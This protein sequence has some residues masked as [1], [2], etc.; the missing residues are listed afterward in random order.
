MQFFTILQAKLHSFNIQD[1]IEARASFALQ[2]IELTTYN[3]TEFHNVGTV[4][5][6]QSA[7]MWFAGL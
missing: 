5:S 3:S 6:E 7:P 2:I 4:Q 1:D